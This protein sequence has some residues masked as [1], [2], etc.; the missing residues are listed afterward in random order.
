MQQNAINIECISDRLQAEITHLPFTDK[1][2]DQLIRDIVAAKAMI[3]ECVKDGDMADTPFAH[4][5][6]FYTFMVRAGWPPHFVTALVMA[7]AGRT[8][9]RPLTDLGG[10]YDAVFPPLPRNSGT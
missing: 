8:A 7:D 6:G 2:K 9:P 3:D 5:C 10:L 4:G 1:G